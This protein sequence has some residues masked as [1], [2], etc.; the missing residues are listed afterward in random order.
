MAKIRIKQIK[1]SIK[2][3][4]NQKLVLESLGL[5]KINHE[6]EHENTP[7]IRGMIN[8]VKHLI[9]ISEEN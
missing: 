6:I 9:E 3:P 4:K 5:K 8:K 1:S 7:V 2:R